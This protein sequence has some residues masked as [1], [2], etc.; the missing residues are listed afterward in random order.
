MD[1]SLFDLN[2][3]VLSSL[4]LAII[5]SCVHTHTQDA[6]FVNGRNLWQTTATADKS[7]EV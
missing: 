2:N 7:S 4:G 1:T 6:N 5:Q 3:T